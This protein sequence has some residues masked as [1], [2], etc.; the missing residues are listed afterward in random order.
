[1]LKSST[2]G[3]LTGYY[4]YYLLAIFRGKVAMQS[5]PPGLLSLLVACFLERCESALM[6]RKAVAGS[7][8][9][10]STQSIATLYA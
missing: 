10:D 8:G 3:G 1:M 9:A 2:Q 4:Y 6:F 5:K 7:K